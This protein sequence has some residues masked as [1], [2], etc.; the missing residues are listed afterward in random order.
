MAEVPRRLAAV[1]EREKAKL[2]CARSRGWRA[3]TFVAAGIVTGGLLPLGP[4]LAADEQPGQRF[5]VRPDRLAKPYATPNVSNGPDYIARPANAT[6]RLPPGFRA[7]LFARGLEEP[8]WMTVA[9][10]GD[11]FL[12]DSAADRIMLLRDADGDGTAELVR[13]FA[14]GFDGPHGLAI[15]GDYLY[16]ADTRAVWRLAYRSGQMRSSAAPKRLTKP[17]ALGD[18]QGHWTRNIVFSPDGRRFFVAIG[19]RAN[20]A[21]EAP[22]RATVQMF[23]ADG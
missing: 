12:A 8:R 5:T 7:T 3:L 4:A 22:P 18:P 21:E 11:V 6:L 17:G 14:A 23:G 16:I 19:S 10:N 13:V 20:L 1:I 9:P 2:R 15:R